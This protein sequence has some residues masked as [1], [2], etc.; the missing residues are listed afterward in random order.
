[1]SRET[2]VE[3][4]ALARCTASAGN[5]QPLK[6]ILSAAPETNARIFS[7]LSWAGYLKDWDGPPPGERPTGYMV[8]LVDET[9]TKDW[10]CD[11]GIAAQTILLGA[12]EKGYG[13][14]MFGSVQRERLRQELAIPDHLRIRLV[15]ALGKPVETVVMEDL[16][17]GGDIRYWRD[18]KGIHHVPKRP[19]EELVLS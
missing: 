10:W 11:D 5:R 2:L 14:C 19:M 9:I 18:E 13:G 12:V 16:K 7:C 8:I 17:P 1:M 15:V 6:Y 3:L 4:V